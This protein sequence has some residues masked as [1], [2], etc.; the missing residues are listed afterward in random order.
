MNIAKNALMVGPNTD[1]ENKYRSILSVF[2]EVKI[3]KYNTTFGKQWETVR[4]VLL[5]ESN[6]NA[7]NQQKQGKLR[8]NPWRRTSTFRF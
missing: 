5:F 8:K 6:T 4:P 3:N 7:P 1:R 2:L